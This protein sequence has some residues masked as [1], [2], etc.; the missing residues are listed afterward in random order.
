MIGGRDICED[1]RRLSKC[2]AIVATLGRLLH[3][4]KN[5]VISIKQ[6]KLVVLDEADKLI[7]S[8]FRTGIDE[9]FKMFSQKPQVIASSA[10]YAN[11]LD[12]LLLT[13]MQNPAAV[14]A[15]HEMPTLIG[16]KQF[17]HVVLATDE[18]HSEATTPIIKMMK[19]K[20][21]AIEYIL[22]RVSF[23]QCILF[24]NSQMRAESFFTYLTS[25]GWKVDLI[26]GS[27][28]QPLRTSTFQKFCKF[29]SRILIAS[30]VLARGID[31]G[32][33]NLVINLDVPTDSSTY[34]HRIG[35]CGR[36]GTYGIAI[37]LINDD[38]DMKQFEK[39]LGTLGTD[40]IKVSLLPLISELDNSRLWDF[41]NKQ[42]DAS[43]FDE[44]DAASND[45]E[46]S[47]DY[48][49]ISSNVIESNQN[50]VDTHNQNLEL[51]QISKSMLENKSQCNVQVDVD[52]FTDYSNQDDDVTS[53]T[54]IDK[55]DAEITA[56]DVMSNSVENSNEKHQH[57]DEVIKIRE[58]DNFKH[59]AFLQ[60]V[61]N[62]QICHE[63]HGESPIPIDSK[64][65]TEDSTE[66][67]TEGKPDT[68]IYVAAKRNKNAVKE[69]DGVRK[70]YSGAQNHWQHIYWQQFNQINQYFCWIKSGLPPK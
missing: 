3:L 24:S 38:M 23:K 41:S 25:N 54:E 57:I 17:V 11:G 18:T 19:C 39:M 65:E 64:P 28:E 36:F 2:K 4:I 61:K 5:C 35:R 55:M 31:V 49:E 44:S 58:S 29:E 12:K 52:L 43:I 63:Y 32:N 37:T 69:R 20:V 56:Y 66:D 30:D 9:L 50:N 1:R 22:K 27:H 13:Y 7:S 16:I 10:T 67:S 34:L 8:D 46:G 6:I 26:I 68:S 14:S 47:G 48:R 40:G 15:T 53:N 33:V 59:R 51:L 45:G 62:L 42:S 70:S 21:N 60:A